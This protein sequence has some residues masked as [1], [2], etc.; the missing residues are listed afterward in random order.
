ME[1]E[2]NMSI[3]AKVQISGA[4]FSP[5]P[6]VAISRG[7]VKKWKIP[8]KITVQFGTFKHTAT[9]LTAQKL[10]GL[11]INS[12]LAQSTGL[13]PGACV[14]MKYVPA[15]RTLRLGPLVGVLM[16]RNGKSSVFGN[17]TMFCQ[18]LSEAGE[19]YGGCFYFFTPGDIPASANSV[20]GWF[21]HKGWHRASFPFPDIVYNRLT[22]RKTEN[23]P[24][25]QH[26]LREVKSKGG[27][28]F[29]ERFLDKTEVFQLL[30]NNAAIRPYL[31]ESHTFGNFAML[32]NMCRKY[33]AVF[34]KPV[35][36]SLGKGII[37]IIRKTGGGYACQYSAVN[38]T[39]TRNFATL[40]QLYQSI[41]GKLKR[42]RYQIQQGLQLIE[43][44]KR[45]MDFRALV[46]KNQT[47]EWQV[48][49]IVARIAG[50]QHFVSNL[51]RGGTLSHAKEALNQSNLG[52]S[53]AGVVYQKLKHASLTIAKALENQVHDHFGELGIDLAVS[54]SGRVWLLEVNSKPSKHDNTPLS[55]K[56]IRP[57]VKQ[58]VQYCRHLARL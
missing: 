34:L 24:S 48:T 20:H 52:K 2:P 37:R 15:S 32:K 45:P 1:G 46:Q 47:G 18:E 13:W 41:S 27:Q 56:K 57:S 22:S 3:K 6:V 43:A 10:D 30:R 36:G 4:L 7:N 55:D 14:R 11:R 9:V 12:Q 39:R 44:G 16:P 21:Y 31:P 33:P 54:K 58:L 40:S 42:N 35:R 28:V 50:N 25:V 19:K 8:G 5:E 17:N 38:G 26:F 23:N 51:A 49:S 29:N 53:K